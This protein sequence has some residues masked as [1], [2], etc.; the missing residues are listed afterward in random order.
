MAQTLYS[1][2]EPVHWRL[3]GPQG[4][5][6]DRMV[7][8]F[9]HALAGQGWQVFCRREYHSNIIGRHSYIDVAVA[10]QTVHCHGESLDMLVSFEA[11]TLARHSQACRAG[12]ILIHAEADT[13]LALE[14]LR[15]LD[16]RL[17]QDLVRQLADRDQPA[18]TAGLL[19]LAR[20]RGVRTVAI[21]F[22]NWL[23]TLAR[24]AGLPQRQVVPAVNT[25]AVSVSAALL[26]LSRDALQ[27]AVERVFAGRAAAID[28]NR[29]AVEL[30]W[31]EVAARPDWPRQDLPA[32]AEAAASAAAALLLNG[33]QSVAL[34]KLAAGLGLQTYY[35]I[36]PASDESVW[37]EAH[38]QLVTPD[39]EN[40]GPL[41][42]QVEDELAAVNM[43]SGAA[44]TGARTAT[45]TSGPGLSLMTEGLGWAGM[46]E[47]PLVITHYQRGGPS[48]GMPTRTEQGDLQFVLH[49]G[50]GEFP[51][52][53]LA[54]ADVESSFYDAAQAFDYAEQFQLPVIHL[55]DKAL[56]SSL[57]TVPGFDLPRLHI[58]RGALGV[59]A[60]G[61]PATASPFPRFA[62]TGSGISPRPRLGEA[63]GQHW[64]T[65]VEH[66]DIGEVTEDPL[67]R[68]RMMEKRARKLATAA[69]AI[70]LAEKLQVFGKPEAACTVLCWGS[71]TGALRDALAR[72]A[73][74][75]RGLELRI[76]QLRLLWPFPA[77]E[78]DP[79]L[80]TA[81]PLVV[82]EAN[83]SGQFEALLRSQTGRR[84]DH[85]ILKYSGRPF[86]GEALVPYLR[87]IKSGRA[88]SRIVIRNPY[89]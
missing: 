10:S 41:I 5:G 37:L 51:R 71:T 77:A 39:G 43:A 25:L 1:V 34:G 32:P 70:P 58:E 65:G 86:S 33:T 47:V 15:F 80:E 75:G 49:A 17:R 59:P 12:A 63:G 44:L 8:L 28:I 52:L 69:A 35:P 78:L 24:Q 68:E 21:P 38:N 53:V 20:R 9:A 88:E 67:W 55:L 76:V 40:T 48:T 26:G 22:R 7:A 16:E 81:A 3:G 54:S 64:L 19:T 61:T 85:L 57:Q 87:Q 13:D 23:E 36:S 72:L 73:Q 2:A 31:S 84:A 56:S 11:E 83:A 30:A 14:R 79:L 27:T 89:E 62:P 18:S 46:N 66:T 82:V 42:L 4:S 45:S 74:E 60:A 50:H 29:Q 6:L